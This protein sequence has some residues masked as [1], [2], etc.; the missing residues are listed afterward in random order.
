LYSLGKVLAVR[1]DQFHDRLAAVR[2][3]FA[4][5]LMDKINETSAVLPDLGGHGAEVVEAVAA[6]YRRIHGICG[7]GGAVG[8]PATGL[9]A[10]RVEDGLIAAYR[11]RRGLAAEEVADL[12]NTLAAL[13]AAAQAELALPDPPSTNTI[14]E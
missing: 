4:S 8:F 1:I 6:S 10:K 5:S 14:E 12:E 9:A 2:K 13:S 3:R 11:A 7:V